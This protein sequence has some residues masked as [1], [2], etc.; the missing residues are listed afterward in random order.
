MSCIF[1]GG[2]LTAVLGP[3]GCG[4]TTL[5]NAIAGRMQNKNLK[6][7]LS[8]NGKEVDPVEN[9][10]NIGFVPAHE[11]LFA[12]DTPSEAFQFVSNLTLAGCL[13]SARPERVTQMLHLLR[14][15][16]CSDTYIGS[17][18]LKGVSSG[19]KKRVSIG[20]ELISDREVLFLDEP[21]TGLDSETALE[22]IHLL[23]SIA[24][25]GIC[26]VA[27]IHQPSKPIWDA[28]DNALFMVNGEVVYHGPASLVTEYFASRSFVC[29]SEYNPPDYLMFLLQT[30]GDGAIA[31]LVNE[32][33]PAIE[34]TIACIN[35]S[36]KTFND[37]RIER[38][39]KQFTRV[40]PADQFAQLVAREYRST[41]RDPSLV[42]LRLSIALGFAIM[43]GFLFFQV[44]K[45]SPTSPSTVGLVASLGIFAF[46]SSGQSLLLAY[47]AERPIAL[48]EFGSGFYSIW[49][50]SISK[51]VLEYPVVLICVLIYLTFGYLIGGLNGSFLLLVCDFPFSLCS[52]NLSSLACY[53][54]GWRQQQFRSCLLP[55]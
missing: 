30:L 3:S 45:S 16:N 49:I 42:A 13:K 47:A 21:T 18:L 28:F 19:E 55:F 53:L 51:D 2:T 8:I 37:T 41:L 32:S 9:R 34:K 25:T 20:I 50:Y 39:L 38:K 12:T 5:L 6:I 48:K 26:I 31:E 1:H 52:I 40:G 14:L 29:P 7:S 35:V 24:S 17:S 46:V 4:K 44:G 23:K 54:P 11:A 15:E 36:R 33:K 27:V 10:V 43:I 22:L